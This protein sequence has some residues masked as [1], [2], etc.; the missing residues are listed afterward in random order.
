M[1][2][3]VIQKSKDGS[4]QGFYCMGHAEYAKNQNGD[5]L[6]AA[7]STLTTCTINALEQLGGETLSYAVNEE[8]GFLKCDF[9]SVLQE[10][11]AFLVD[12]MVFSL[13]SLAKEYGNK[14]LQIKFEEV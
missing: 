5:V 8:T 9:K 7:I 4:Y 11:S 3:I 1:T 6:C 12:A 10:K 14:Y 2:K 13:E